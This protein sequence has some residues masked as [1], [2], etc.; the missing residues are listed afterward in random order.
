MLYIIL[1]FLG[2][3]SYGI[4]STF[5]KLAYAKGFIASEVIGSQLFLGCLMLWFAVLCFSRI[6]VNGKAIVKLML[7]GLT[8]CMTSIFY[9]ISLQTIPA[10]IAIVLLFQFTWIGVVLE[11]VV[12]RAF[13][14]REKLVSIGILT[15]GTLLA[16]A[17][18]EHGEANL[19]IKGVVL[20]L[21][22]ALTFA[23]FIFFS[24]RVSI[25]IPSLNRSAFIA[26]GSFLSAF[27]ILRPSFL[28]DGTFQ[29][30]LWKYGLLLGLFGLFIPTLFFAI[31]VPKIGSGLGTILG[32]AELPMAVFMSSVVLGETVTLL[33]WMGVVLILLGIAFPQWKLYYQKKRMPVL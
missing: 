14:S 13:P 27:L 22:S 9:Y 5:V 8:V 15:A 29:E 32:A 25:Q 4:L 33:Q 30:G 3:C 11:A 23:L 16:G 21:L 31:G 20:G 12:E 18:F 2:A 24:G 6:K 1:V 28:V 10:S 19:D 7:V 17:V 26:T